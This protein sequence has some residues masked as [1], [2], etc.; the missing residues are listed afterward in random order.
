MDDQ[1]VA[2]LKKYIGKDVHVVVDR[3]I[4]YVHGDIV[5][6]INYG[7]IPGT[8]AGDDEE[9]DVYILGVDV[10]VSSFDGRVIGAVLRRDDS[11]DKL[12]VAPSGVELHQAQI[13]QAVNFQEKFF[14]VLIISALEQSC[15]VLPYREVN[16]NWEFLLVYESYSR[17][18]SLPKGHMERGETEIQTALR[19]LYEETGLT[20]CLDTGKKAVIEYAISSF[21][22]KRVVFF[23]GEVSG[24]PTNRPGE[25]E[26]FCWVTKEQLGEYLFADTVRACNELLEDVNNV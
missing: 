11:E 12:V 2:L 26:R 18:W 9:Q 5:Y 24:V 13:A 15:G 3:P 1:R 20:A 22:R 17:C 6:S 25:I 7:Y 8:I 14:D 10:P 4:G 19:E 21:A 23:L 16:G